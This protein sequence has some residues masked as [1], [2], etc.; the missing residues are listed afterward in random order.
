MFHGGVLLTA[1][2]LSSFT[3]NN[4]NTV[5]F[6]G[7]GCRIINAE[8]FSAFCRCEEWIETRNEEIQIVRM[9]QFTKK[10]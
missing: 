6:L 9:F 10:K 3:N 5:R 4:N 7:N 8:L 1:N 2:I